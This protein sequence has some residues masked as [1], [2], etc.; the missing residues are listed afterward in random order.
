MHDALGSES[1]IQKFRDQ[2]R[3]DEGL[4]EAIDRSLRDNPTRALEQIGVKD[5]EIFDELTAIEKEAA[6]L[7]QFERDVPKFPIPDIDNHN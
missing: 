4:D 6:A 3:Y 7:K 5:K 2:T 1:S